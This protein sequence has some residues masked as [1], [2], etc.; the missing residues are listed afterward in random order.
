MSLQLGDYLELFK[1]Y[2]LCGSVPEEL[3]LQLCVYLPELFKTYELCG[4]VWTAC[5]G[6]RLICGS[7]NTYYMEQK[8]LTNIHTYLH[9]VLIVCSVS[10][11]FLIEVKFLAVLYLSIFLK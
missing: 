4:T 1:T 3:N 10:F 6:V 11:G 7:V 2:E 8:P 5:A 9:I